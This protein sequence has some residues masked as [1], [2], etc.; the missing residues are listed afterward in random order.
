MRKIEFRA[1]SLTGEW[2]KGSYIN[3]GTLGSYI[4]RNGVFDVVPVDPETVGENTSLTV[5]ND[6]ELFE[7]DIVDYNGKIAV[8]IWD[9]DNACFRLHANFYKQFI[10][11]YSEC[12]DIIIV[13]NV[14]DNLKEFEE[15]IMRF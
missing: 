15:R 12:E 14:H 10:Q 7:G 13:G 4:V 6:D 8:V 11:K 3:R 5:K 1:K 2:V 9:D